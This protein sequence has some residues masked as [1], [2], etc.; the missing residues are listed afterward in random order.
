MTRR[1]PAVIAL[2]LAF[3]YCALPQEAA[4]ASETQHESAEQGDPWIWWKWANFAILATGLGYLIGKQAPA[5]FRRR[6]DELQQEMA[7]ASRAESEARA[8]AASMTQRLAGLRNEIEALRAAAKTEISAEAE[9]IR[10]ETERHLQRVQKQAAQEIELMGRGARDQL[11]KYYA[12]LAISLAE[13]RVGARI[14]KDVQDGLVDDF[15]G[16]LRAAHPASVR[17]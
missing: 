13:Q 4:K 7:E 2:L 6:F 8:Q 17:T 15:L 1:I 16:G 14:T 11:K 10:T 5:L 3:S 9:R 12:E